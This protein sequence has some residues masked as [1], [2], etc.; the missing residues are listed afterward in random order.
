[1]Q[2]SVQARVVKRFGS[3]VV[4]MAFD[5]KGQAA[6]EADKIRIC[7]RSYDLLVNKVWR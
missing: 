4:V 3:A 1:M 5:E 6:T 2:C 7:K